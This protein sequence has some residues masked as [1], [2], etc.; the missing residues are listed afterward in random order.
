MRVY[1]CHLGNAFECL[2]GKT[3]YE[4]DCI[5]NVYQ[6]RRKQWVFVHFGIH[7]LSGRR[8]ILSC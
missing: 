4:V 3:R 5:Y 2:N 6:F 8:G 1:F 7:I